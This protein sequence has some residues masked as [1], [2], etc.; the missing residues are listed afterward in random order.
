MLSLLFDIVALL[1]Y[2]NSDSLVYSYKQM[3][4]GFSF[5]A[6]LLAVAK[7]RLRL[8]CGDAAGKQQNKL[9]AG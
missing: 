1:S 7:W 4:G 6:V 2:N 8:S 5:R 3:I 9:H